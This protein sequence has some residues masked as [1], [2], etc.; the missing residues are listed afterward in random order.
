MNEQISKYPRAEFIE[1]TQAV[2]SEVPKYAD[3]NFSILLNKEGFGERQR[4]V[5]IPELPDGVDA[6]SIFRLDL[7]EE[8]FKIFLDIKGGG[9][10]RFYASLDEASE[11][12]SVVQMFLMKESLVP[13]SPGATG[14][15]YVGVSAG[16][17]LQVDLGANKFVT[18]ELA[19][20]VTDVCPGIVDFLNKLARGE[21]TVNTAI[22]SV[23][24]PDTPD[25]SVSVSEAPYTLAP[26]EHNPDVLRL[27]EPTIINPDD[28]E[29]IYRY[30][31]VEPDTYKSQLAE[32]LLSR[33]EIRNRV[34]HALSSHPEQISNPEAGVSIYD[35]E[36]EDSSLKY[37]HVADA[38][39]SLYS[40]R[41][42]TPTGVLT[43]GYDTATGAMHY[44]FEGHEK[45][46]FNLSG[47][48]A[49]LGTYISCTFRWSSG[50]QDIPQDAAE[51]Q[52]K[53]AQLK[54]LIKHFAILKADVNQK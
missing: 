34:I 19:S 38:D 23:D 24:Y 20:L 43:C 45:L 30:T 7:E 28:F 3:F 21:V 53:P 27:F 22:L 13:L 49:S 8:E 26:I 50:D 52:L 5:Q 39:G 44:S 2:L 10:F 46:I 12:Q 31:S 54:S 41:L 4:T 17:D 42:T 6:I 15:S 37:S 25:N 32:V 1:Q 18:N 40:I 14:Y 11:D 48:D 51:K 35:D 9:S 47:T 29:Q 16:G 36:R 33:V